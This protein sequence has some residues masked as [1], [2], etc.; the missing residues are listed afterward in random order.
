MDKSFDMRYLR[1][2]N[3]TQKAVTLS[4]DDGV[5]QD[6]RLI[7]IM[8]KHG[9]KGTFNINSGL[10]SN[11]YD[12]Q[13][14]KGRMTKQEAIDLYTKSG[15]EVAI[16]GTLHLSL[17]GVASDLAMY[18]V[19]SDRNALESMFGRIMKGMAYANGSYND[20]VV[21]IVK[22]AGIHYARTCNSTEMFDL[23]NDWLRL[24]ATCHHNNPQLMELAKKFV[25][26][27]E[28]PYYWSNTLQLFYLWGHS[29]EFDNNDNWDII[30]KF[31]EYIGGRADIWYATNGEIYEYLQAAKLLQFSVDGKLVKN[32]SGVDIYIRYVT[33]KCC[34]PAGKMV[35]LEDGT[36]I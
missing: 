32:P 1:F 6:K 23:P 30:E 33:G 20:E 7:A 3:F 13:E 35:C 11:N 22:K 21:E 12:G 24:P 4:Y 29:Y 2:P 8:Q 25:E 9:L 27:K 10:F 36:I 26:Q 19:V 16:H 34:V 28:H 15:M 14:E 31:A 18:D 17:T 5:R